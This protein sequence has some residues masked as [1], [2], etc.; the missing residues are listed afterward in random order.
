MYSQ[1]GEKWWKTW[2]AV[3]TEMGGK[4]LLVDN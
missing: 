1:W 3:E 4:P 2:T